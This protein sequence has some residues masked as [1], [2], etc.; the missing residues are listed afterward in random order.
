MLL[1]SFVGGTGKE[2]FALKEEDEII[3]TVT[4]ELDGLLEIEG[5][6]LTARVT[7]WKKSNIQFHVGHPEVVRKI[8]GYIEN[9]PRLH[10]ATAGIRGMGIPD[11]IHAGQEAACEIVNA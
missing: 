1:R 6:P 2:G 4:S 9:I 3:E 10:L 7:Q 8:T 11:R 5:D